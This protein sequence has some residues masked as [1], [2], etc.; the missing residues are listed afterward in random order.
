MIYED[1]MWKTRPPACIRT[2]LHTYSKDLPCV[3][4]FRF[5]LIFVHMTA[6]YKPLNHCSARNL[7][8]AWVGEGINDPT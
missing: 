8:Q 4:L 1:N 5:V 6:L 7:A 2:T 3:F